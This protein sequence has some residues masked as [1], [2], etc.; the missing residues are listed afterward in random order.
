MA[1]DLDRV[2]RPPPCRVG[3]AEAEPRLLAGPLLQGEDSRR[4]STAH[5]LR[6]QAMPHIISTW[7]A[8]TPRL[9]TPRSQQGVTKRRFRDGSCSARSGLSRLCSAALRPPRVDRAV[10]GPE[11]HGSDFRQHAPPSARRP[12]QDRSKRGERVCNG[13]QPVPRP[14]PASPLASYSC[15]TLWSRTKARQV[16]LSCATIRARSSR[17]A[18]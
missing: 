7:V 9:A 14:L 2:G 17:V 12:S 1:A 11:A 16:S 8:Q 6:R 5:A 13:R 15:G 18:L 4:T 3:A 10:R